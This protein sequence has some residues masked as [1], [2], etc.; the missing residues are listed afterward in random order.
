MQRVCVLTDNTAQFTRPNFPGHERVFVIPF[1]L[2]PATRL[3]EFPQPHPISLPQVIPPSPQ[4]FVDFYGRLSQEFDFILVLTISSLL[5]ST[6]KHA[7]SAS[8]QSGHHAII[9]V[10]D[11]QST[12]VGLGLLVQAAAGLASAGAALKEIAHQVRTSI[13]RIYTLFCIPELSHLAQAGFLEHSQAQAGE[14]LGLLPIFV[15]EDGRLT[16]TQKVRTPRHLFESFQEFLGEFDNP[17]HIALLR[18]VNHTTS[19]TRP[20]RQFVQ[21]TFPDTP[22]SEHSL[23]QPLA[24]LFGPQSIGLVVME[25][26]GER[27][28]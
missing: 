6:M 8:V 12:A 19:R 26:P 28:K 23:N 5:N 25:K 27:R 18:G 10:V 16:P 17:T 15:L 22:F 4:A 9:E 21:E 13:P 14:M 11:S 24:A 20:L 2:Q 7:L 1:D 3:G